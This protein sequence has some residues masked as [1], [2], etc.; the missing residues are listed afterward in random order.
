MQYEGVIQSIIAKSAEDAAPEK[1]MGATALLFA[2]ANAYTVIAI[3]D[4]RKIIVQRDAVLSRDK[5]GMAVTAPDEAGERRVLR[6]HA[7]GRWKTSDGTVFVLGPRHEFNL[8][9]VAGAV[10]APAVKM[11]QGPVRR[12]GRPKGSKTKHKEG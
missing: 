3:L 1:G 11:E 12:P 2:A 4:D 7:C 5:T 6:R 10:K 8:A 9:Q